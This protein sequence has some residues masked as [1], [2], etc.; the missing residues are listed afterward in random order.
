MPD[1]ASDADPEYQEEVRLALAAVLEYVL[2]GIAAGEHWQRAIPPAAVEQ[3]RR[4]A[5]AD[6]SLGVI[7]R[8]YVAVHARLGEHLADAAAKRKPSDDDLTLQR[9]RHTQDRLLDHVIVAVEREYITERERACRP[10]AEQRGAIVRRLLRHEPVD[11]IELAALGYGLKSRWHIGVVVAGAQSEQALNAIRA[12]LYSELL[13]VGSRE[14]TIW[15]W[16]GAERRLSAPA[17]DDHLPPRSRVRLAIGTPRFGLDGWRRTHLEALAVWPVALRGRPG[18]THCGDVTIDA[19]LLGNEVLAT[20]HRETFLL[21]LDRLRD[22]GQTAR[23]TLHAYFACERNI[24]S[25][26][27]KLR[28]TRRTVENRLH[29]IAESLGRP[30]RTCLPEIEAALRLESSL[31]GSQPTS[32]RTDPDRVGNAPSSQMRSAAEHIVYCEP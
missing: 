27:A 18:A 23:D 11:Q 5:R 8:R 31:H 12:G 7:I 4:A 21:P 2:D 3:A 28:V 1:P 24:A 22:G 20:L 32:A 29:A 26:S 9:L 17:I 25:T 19:A 10:R 6:V 13:A 15:A 16:L 14:G 30:L